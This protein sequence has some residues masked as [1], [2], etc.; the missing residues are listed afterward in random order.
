ML[1]LW[2]IRI[3]ILGYFG[4]IYPTI[5]N[6]S[7][8]HHLN[9]LDLVICSF[10]RQLLCKSFTLNSLF[11]ARIPITTFPFNS[12]IFWFYV[13]NG[14]LIILVPFSAS[15]PI[16]SQALRL[17]QHTN[18]LEFCT[19]LRIINLLVGRVWGLGCGKIN[20]VDTLWAPILVNFC[21]TFRSTRVLVLNFIWASLGWLPYN[22]VAKCAQIFSWQ[23]LTV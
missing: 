23:A 21:C 13:K 15:S 18:L 16:M 1:V 17:L 4:R 12:N 9:S 5:A 19:Y 20:A 22:M 11:A 10:S 6:I 2:R 8:W 3:G 7:R 14:V